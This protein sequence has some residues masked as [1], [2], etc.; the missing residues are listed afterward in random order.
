MKLI[1]VMI[2]MMMM[3][4]AMMLTM[5]MVVMIRMMFVEIF[6]LD[7]WERVCSC[8]ITLGLEISRQEGG[9]N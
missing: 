8:E 4:M 5:M 1:I 3:M 2:I 9:L 7:H 6:Y